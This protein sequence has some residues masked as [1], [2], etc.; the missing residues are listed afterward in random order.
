MDHERVV[1]HG[2]RNAA[3]DPFIPVEVSVFNL[4]LHNT[5]THPEPI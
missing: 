5:L 2:G 3:L 1:L 4:S